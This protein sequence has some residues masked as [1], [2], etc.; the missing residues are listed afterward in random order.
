M[1]NDLLTQAEIYCKEYKH[2]LTKPRLEVLKTIASSQ[3]PIGAYEVLSKL[4]KILN[5]PKPPTIYRAIE[6]WQKNHFIHRIE[7]LSAFVICK[8][9][10]LH[11]GSHFMIC[12]DC[13]VVIE[14]HLCEMPKKLN[15]CTIENNFSPSHWSVEIHGLC[16]NC[17]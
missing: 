13:G 1:N 5:N 7:S 14:S 9:G 3:A 2:R 17:A 11:Q 10:H 15:N 12:D 16:K 4:N 6:F 8:A